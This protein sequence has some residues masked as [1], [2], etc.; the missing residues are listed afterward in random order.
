MAQHA[1][2]R[3]RQPGHIAGDAVHDGAGA[4]D[5][6]GVRVRPLPAGLMDLV[7]I[8]GLLLCLLVRLSHR[9]SISIKTPAIIPPIVKHVTMIL[10]VFMLGV[11]SYDH[12]ANMLL[13]GRWS[14]RGGIPKFNERP[15]SI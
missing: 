12:M 3:R 8:L 10:G 4:T 6:D 13:V 5:D 15:T 7:M 1:A 11:G 14:V 2:L 9:A